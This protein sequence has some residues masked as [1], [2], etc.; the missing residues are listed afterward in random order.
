MENGP[1]GTASIPRQGGGGQTLSSSE[2]EIGEIRYPAALRLAQIC[3]IIAVVLVIFGGLAIVGW[4]VAD[5]TTGEERIAAIAATVAGTAFAA[6]FMA[7]LGHVLEI[8]VGTYTQVWE[9]RFPLDE[10]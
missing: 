6:T 4:I 9:S 5:G 8:L 3:R 2:K 10:D 7:F 1:V